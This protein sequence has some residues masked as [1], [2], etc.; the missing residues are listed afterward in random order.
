MHNRTRPPPIAQDPERLPFVATATLSCPTAPQDL[1][2]F[3]ILKLWEDCGW[4]RGRCRS[5]GGVSSGSLAQNAPLS[6]GK[7]KV[8]VCRSTEKVGAWSLERSWRSKSIGRDG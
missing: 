6:S 8:K 3:Q 7:R 4:R 5:P 1:E 2:L